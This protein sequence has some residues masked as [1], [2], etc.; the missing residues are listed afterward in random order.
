MVSNG[1][2]YVVAQLRD[3]CNNVTPHSSDINATI[4]LFMNERLKLLLGRVR[5]NLRPEKPGGVIFILLLYLGGFIYLFYHYH[6]S[7]ETPS[8]AILYTVASVVLVH[9]LVHVFVHPRD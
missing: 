6:H 3:S 7:K 2:N 5:Q 8:E 4:G 1:L 9:L